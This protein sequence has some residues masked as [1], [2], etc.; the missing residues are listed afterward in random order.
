MSSLG[1]QYLPEEGFG[2][3]SQLMPYGSALNLP[4]QVDEAQSVSGNELPLTRYAICIVPP[5]D[6]NFVQTDRHHA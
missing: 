5:V 4:G 1:Q 3:M 2:A 6:L